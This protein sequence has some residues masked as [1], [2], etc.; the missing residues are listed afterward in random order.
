MESHEEN[1][2]GF[3]EEDVDDSL[4]NVDPP[5]LEI[6]NEDIEDNEDNK[7]INSDIDASQMKEIK[8]KKKEVEVEEEEDEDEEEDDD[9][10]GDEEEED[11][12]PI[13][14]NN[15]S[16]MIVESTTTMDE[17]I[18][19]K[20]YVAF[21]KKKHTQVLSG[22]EFIKINNIISKLINQNTIQIP[23]D[24]TDIEFR[25]DIICNN[26]FDIKIH[27]PIGLNIW[28]KVNINELIISRSRLEEKLK[29]LYY[30]SSR[31]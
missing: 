1:S 28:V 4:I 13:I 17:S 16:S 18:G 21:D 23:S 29:N 14:E 22:Y 5:E 24:K 6:Y 15:I 20:I 12:I 11:E 27:R 25:L 19:E 10:D 7:S 31:Q 8:I 26:L 9:G 3:E 30:V 2:L